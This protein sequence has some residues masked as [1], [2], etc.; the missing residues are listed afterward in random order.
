MARKGASTANPG[1]AGLDQN[2]RTL[3]TSQQIAIVDLTRLAIAFYATVANTNTLFGMGDS[4]HPSE[5]GATLISGVVAKDL[6]AG[7]LPLRDLL[8]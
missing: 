4:T 1:F 2:V 3:A 6:K 8:K 7:T 5:L